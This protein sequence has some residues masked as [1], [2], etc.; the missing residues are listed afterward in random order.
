MEKQI[1]DF[2][3]KFKDDTKLM[4]KEFFNKETNK[5]QRANMWTFSRLVTSF[6]IPICALL[7][8]LT[9]NFALFVGSILLTSFG[10]LTDFIDGRSAKKH[11]SFSEYGRSLDQIADK[12]FSSMISITLTLFNPLFLIAL[13]GE[14]TIA[15]TNASYKVKYKKL[16]I[17]STQ[18]GRIK[19]W[20]LFIS[21]VLGFLS[22]LVPTISVATNISI[23]IT[24]LLQIATTIS[25]IE[26]NNK[27]INTLE[28]QNL[29]NNIEEFDEDFEKDKEKTKNNIIEN[30]IQKQNNN[31]LS[32][33]E[34]CENLRNLR[35]ELTCN[36]HIEKLENNN[37]YKTKK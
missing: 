14:G 21:L 29:I 24:F 15:I 35:N 27:I 5:K 17:K 9:T 26:N 1:K 34:Q 33:T 23:G 4:F 32:R 25:Y 18:I 36:Q 8:I 19:Q 37:L 6:L 30:N 10:A 7:S 12:I 11:N 28:E 13:L 2:W 20:P 22:V 3:L 16:K 31:A